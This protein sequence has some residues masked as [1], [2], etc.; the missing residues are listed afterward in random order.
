MHSR[1][2]F[3]I[4][5][6]TF[7]FAAF[8]PQTDRAQPPGKL[9]FEI[10][11]PSLRSAAHLTGRVVLVLATTDNPEP[12]FQTGYTALDAAQIF[13]VDVNDWPP[14]TPVTVDASTLGYP[15]D[16]LSRVPAGDYYVQAVLNIYQTYHLS[17]GH[18]V[19]LPPDK[20]EGQHW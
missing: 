9:H 13:G 12:R 1:R 14:G 5:L 11:F 2:N 3:A 4:L 8:A 10:S 15:L 7:F 17:N 16:N 19:E 6:V 18:T 20:G